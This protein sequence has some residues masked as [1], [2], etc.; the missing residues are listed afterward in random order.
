MMN[1]AVFPFYTYILSDADFGRTAFIRVTNRIK[2]FLML[3]FPFVRISVRIQ[4]P[5]GPYRSALA[6]FRC[7][8]APL[9]IKTGRYSSLPVIERTCFHCE[10]E[11]E[12]E[13]HVIPRCR[14]YQKIRSRLYEKVTSLSIDFIVYNDTEKIKF[15]L[16]NPDIVQKKCYDI[17]AE[18]RTHIYQIF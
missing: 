6:K 12:D 1:K 16:S 7:G 4:S 2:L 3:V 11:V 13:I 8:V 10:T 9:K 15:V 18:R 14:L 17:L 5:H